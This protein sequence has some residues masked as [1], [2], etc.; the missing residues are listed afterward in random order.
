MLFLVEGRF[1]EARELHPGRLGVAIFG[2]TTEEA[3]MRP[4]NYTRGDMLS[5]HPSGLVYFASMRPGNY[6][7]GDEMIRWG[8]VRTCMLQ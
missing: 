5:D 6:T 1:N 3:S 4:G 7:R 8:I 2:I